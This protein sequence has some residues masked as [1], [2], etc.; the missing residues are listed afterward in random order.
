MTTKIIGTGGDYTT[1][2]TWE[3]DAPVGAL[4]APW[5]GNCKNETFNG[6]DGSGTQITISGNTT[7]ATNH[8]ILTTDTG[9][10]FKDNA[11]KLTNALRYNT[12]NG[13][14]ISSSVGFQHLISVNEQYVEISNL[15]IQFS[16]GSSIRY[17]IIMGGSSGNFRGNN[18][19]IE[20]SGA[21]ATTPSVISSELTAVFVNCLISQRVSGST[22]TVSRSGFGTIT[23]I[24]CTLTNANVTTTALSNIGG[25]SNLVLENC[26]VYNSGTL[27]DTAFTSTTGSSNNSTDLGSI[28]GGSSQVSKTY[29]SQFTDT[30]DASR[31]FRVQAA[32]DLIGA[33]VRDASYT[34]DLDIIGQ[35]RSTSTPTIGCWEYISPSVTNDVFL[36]PDKGDGT[37]SVRL[38]PDAPDAG[39]GT[40]Y[41]LTADANTLVLTGQNA[42]WAVSRFLAANPGALVL[43]GKTAALAITRSLTGVPGSLVLTPI[44][45]GLNLSRNLTGTLNTLTLTPGIASW[46]RA[47]KL[48]SNPGALTLTG[49]TATLDYVPAGGV[50]HSLTADG[51]S[52]TLTG[53]GASLTIGRVLQASPG[54]LNLSGGVTTLPINRSLLAAPNSL[55][56]TGKAATYII[57]RIL[58]ATPGSLILNGSVASLDYVPFGGGGIPVRFLN[59]VTAAHEKTISQNHINLVSTGGGNYTVTLVPSNTQDDQNG[60]SYEGYEY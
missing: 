14:A 54:A 27:N 60:P 13:A 39:G 15:Q 56:F 55:S 25:T 19:I 49:G 5:Q 47:I 30:A 7:D 16:A 40:A 18:L 29:S 31:D 21:T 46:L 26:A 2:S 1:I 37:N 50:N 10:S 6:G 41:S 9:A 52:L 53:I 32:A 36:R 12:S 28:Y 34:A 51:G 59:G 48:L 4:S 43:S 35:A 38:Y 24:N 20:R 17:T 3:A 44:A 57:G 42:L 58:N 33:G 8:K 11:N 45:A 22:N 23:F